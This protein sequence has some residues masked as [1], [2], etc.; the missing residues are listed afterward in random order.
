MFFYYA[1]FQDHFSPPLPKFSGRTPVIGYR[2]FC[3]CRNFRNRFLFK[4]GRVLD[5]PALGAF[6]T[7]VFLNLPIMGGN[8][9]LSFVG[10]TRKPPGLVGMNTPP[11]CPELG[12]DTTSLQS[13]AFEYSVFLTQL[14]TVPPLILHLV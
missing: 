6:L 14:L 5:L 1:L 13:L 8:R 2:N 9:G 4:V 11:S 7:G 3:S 10:A 12:V